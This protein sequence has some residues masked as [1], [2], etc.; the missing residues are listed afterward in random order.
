[1]KARPI[2]F[3]TDMVRALLDGRKT[4]TRR[5]IKAERAQWFAD[6]WGSINGPESWD[7]N[8]WVWALTFEVIHANVDHVL[9]EAT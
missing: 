7:Q 8:P 9:A 6:L 1:M 2:L 3:S 5:I 4:Q